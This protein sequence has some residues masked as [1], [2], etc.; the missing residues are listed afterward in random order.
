MLISINFRRWLLSGRELSETDQNKPL[1]GVAPL[2]LWEFWYRYKNLRWLVSSQ[3]LNPW[4]WIF[5]WLSQ[6]AS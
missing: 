6:A 1:S 5:V 4:F 2:D 3:F